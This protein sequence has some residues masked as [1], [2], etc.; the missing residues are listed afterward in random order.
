M[1][2]ELVITYTHLDTLNELVIMLEKNHL[3]LE[4]SIMVEERESI[5]A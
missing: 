4:K 1:K 2:K 3:E 5:E